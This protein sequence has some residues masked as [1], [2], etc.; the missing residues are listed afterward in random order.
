MQHSK[1]D[2]N[3]YNSIDLA[4]FICAILVVMIHIA[5]FGSSRSTSIIKYLNFG[6]Q[7]YLARIAVPFFFVTSDF[8]LYKKTTLSD[9]NP[10]YSK[11][12][13]IR[14][15]RLYA[16]W[17]LIYFPLVFCDFFKDKKG[18]AH[19]VFAY[20]QRVIFT[21]SYTQLWYLNA[22]IIA[23]IMV[24]FLLYK[25]Y[26]PKKIVVFAS[27]LYFLGLFAQSWF[28]FIVPLREL[29]PDFW[30]FLKILQ[31]VILTTRNGIFDGF[32]FV[33]IGMCFAFFNIKIEKKKALIYFIISMVL[34]FFEVFILEYFHYIRGKDM[35]LFLIPATFFFFCFVIQVELPNSPLFKTLRILSSLIF[36]SH[37]WVNT[38]VSKALKIIYEPLTET[39]LHFVLTIIITI[40]VSLIII[41]SSKTQRF[42]WLKILYE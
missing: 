1:F 4:K 27:L 20:I 3:N 2:R 7:N 33:S 25:K 34:M 15:L 36:Y 40:I 31:K 24:S 22:L 29:T 19:A 41:K 35:Y 10:E 13:I 30:H 18:V 11:K 38:I 26:N 8:L 12:Y 42:K 21:G 9:F 5:P 28:G 23:V 39:C 16:I 17:T 32:I 14:I 6:I 37:L